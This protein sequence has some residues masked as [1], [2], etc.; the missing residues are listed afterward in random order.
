MGNCFGNLIK[1]C[2][3]VVDDVENYCT[4]MKEAATPKN[5]NTDSNFIENNKNKTSN[6]KSYHRLHGH[7]LDGENKIECHDSIKRKNLKNKKPKSR[8]AMKYHQ[9]KVNLL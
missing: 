8:H 6:I 5:G 3:N 1:R 4:K 9:I 2:R 7:E